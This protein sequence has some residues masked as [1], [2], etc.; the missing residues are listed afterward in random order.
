MAVATAEYRRTG[1]GRRGAQSQVWVRRPEGWRIASAHVS[2]GSAADGPDVSHP[3]TSATT[4][5]Q[6]PTAVTSS[7]PITPAGSQR[8]PFGRVPSDKLHRPD[9]ERRRHPLR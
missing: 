4:C 1:S 6:S 5:R 9:R 2:L 3:A 7:A 8:N